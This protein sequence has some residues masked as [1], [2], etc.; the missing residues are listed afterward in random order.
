MGGAPPIFGGYEYTPQGINN[1]LNISTREKTNEALLMLPKLFLASGFSVTITDPP[2]AGDKWIPDL[3]IYD[4]LTSVDAY[5]TDPVYTDRW[6]THNNINLPRRSEVLKRN[7]FYYAIFRESPIAFR[8]ALYYRGSWLAPFSENIMRSFLNG[9][10]VLDFLNELT[11]FEPAM[12]NMAIFMVNNTTHEG[13]F[14]QAPH[15]KPKLTITDYGKGRFS[16]ENFYHINIAAIKRLSEYFDFLKLHNVY[17]NTRIILVSDHGVLDNT[18][19]TKT[20]LPFPVDQFNPLLLVKD[21][22]AK[23]E[24]KTDMTFMSTA[25]VP[26]MAMEGL[27]ENPVN[28]FTGNA[29]T[30]DQK[31]NPLLI[32]TKRVTRKSINGIDLNLH[33]T[34]YVHDN[35][36][37]ENNWS[38]PIKL[39]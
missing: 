25:D 8:Q 27:I 23:G 22:N 24:M 9:Y 31:N 33:N 11:D 5:I 38:R 29:I 34:Y 14:L 10:A 19:V 30:S 15:Y 2:Y 20:N 6:L 4:E 7:I 17:D 21:F 36:F 35:I 3:R 16:K 13:Q 26:S 28:P 32:L 39:P 18:Y 37:D 1:R 12:D